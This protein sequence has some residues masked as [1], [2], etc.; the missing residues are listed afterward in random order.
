MLDPELAGLVGD[1]LLEAAVAENAL[2]VGE[3]V[4]GRFRLE[5]AGDSGAGMEAG[6]VL[7]IEEEYAPV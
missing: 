1:D 4:E 5:M 7:V 3:G 2:Q 6:L